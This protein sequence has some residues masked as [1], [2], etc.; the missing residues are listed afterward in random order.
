M[1]NVETSIYN[2]F[3]DHASCYCSHFGF[4]LVTLEYNISDLVMGVRMGIMD[5]VISRNYNK[6]VLTPFPLIFS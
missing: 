1:K 2:R 3:L 5:T 4:K 6:M